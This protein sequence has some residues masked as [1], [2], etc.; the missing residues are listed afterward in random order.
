MIASTSARFG[1]GEIVRHRESAFRGVVLD[2]DPVFLGRV[3][4]TDRISPD[5]PFYQVL[6]LGEEGGFVAYA[7]EDVLEHDPEFTALSPMDKRRWFNVDPEG[8]HF[9]KAQALH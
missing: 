4:T 2:V 9:P 1:L 8:R 6:A 3:E 5:Q 7:A